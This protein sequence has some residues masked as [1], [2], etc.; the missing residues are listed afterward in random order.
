METGSRHKPFTQAVKLYVNCE[1]TLEEF[2]CKLTDSVD[3][4]EIPELV[5]MLPTDVANDLKRRA[6]RSPKT[7]KEWESAFSVTG[8]TF[9]RPKAWSEE[10]YEA[11]LREQEKEGQIR[12]RRFVEALRAHFAAE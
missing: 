5:A 11:W 6:D 8:G 3:P 9:T 10:Q 7:E 12:S 2:Y 4:S 1:I